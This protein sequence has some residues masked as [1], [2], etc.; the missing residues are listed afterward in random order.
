MNTTELDEL[1]E[2]AFQAR[3]HLQEL[4]DLAAK[5]R[6][7]REGTGW[8]MFVLFNPD[9]ADV[10]LYESHSLLQPKQKSDLAILVRKLLALGYRVDL[11]KQFKSRPL[12]EHTAKL[13]HYYQ[14]ECRVF[15]G[16]E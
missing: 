11:F 1:W 14:L 15:F 6:K 9:P 12:S 10:I 8:K 3:P 16:D 7:A 5:M 13:E 2:K 4:V